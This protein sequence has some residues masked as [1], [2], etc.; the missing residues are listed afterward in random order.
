MFLFQSGYAQIDLIAQLFVY[1]DSLESCLVAIVVPD[2]AALRPAAAK[3]GISS[4]D[5]SDEE[6]CNDTGVK[7]L[8]LAKMKD[9][10]KELKFNSLEIPKDIHVECQM[11]S[12]ENGLLTPTLKNK[13]PELKKH[14]KEKIDAMYAQMNATSN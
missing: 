2:L 1:G 3:N 5:A 14:F 8:I 10:A 6:L 11:F 12:V 7:D 4:K 13:R 9:K